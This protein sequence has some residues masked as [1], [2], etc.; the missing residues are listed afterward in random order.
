MKDQ[1]E[2]ARWTQPATPPN[3]PDFTTYPETPWGRES[4]LLLLAYIYGTAEVKIVQARERRTWKSST[5]VMFSD[6]SH[7]IQP[8]YIRKRLNK[9]FSLSSA[10]TVSI[11]TTG[12]R[13]ARRQ[14]KVSQLSAKERVVVSLSEWYWMSIAWEQVLV[15]VSCETLFHSSLHHSVNRENCLEV[16]L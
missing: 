4:H 1:E 3:T 13:N 6:S 14:P 5:Q 7:T 9:D 10:Q 8:D 16:F 2:K 11:M 12:C 15:W